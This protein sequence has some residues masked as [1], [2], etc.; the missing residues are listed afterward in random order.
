MNHN[1]FERLKAYIV[2]VL[3]ISS[4][5]QVGILWGYQSQ[6]HGF[7]IS[8]LSGIFAGG[9]V[10]NSVE[11][12]EFFRP[13]TI[14]ASSNASYRVIDRKNSAYIKLWDDLRKNYLPLL[15]NTKPVE[16]SVIPFSDDEWG[17]IIAK[18]GFVFDFKTSISTDILSEFLNKSGNSN[19]ELTGIY[20]IAVLP[21]EDINNNLVMYIRDDS[22][23]SQYIFP[24]KG[25]LNRDGYEAILDKTMQDNNLREY[26][27]IRGLDPGKKVDLDNKRLYPIASDILLALTLPKYDPMHEV[28]SSVPDSF[29][30]DKSN[31]AAGTKNLAGVILGD[32]KDIYE[33]AFISDTGDKEASLNIKNEAVVYKSLNNMYKVYNNGLLEY[34]SLSPVES[35]KIDDKKAF[36]N[37]LSFINKEKQLMAAS[38]VTLY[39]SGIKKVDMQYT[40]FTF[41]YCIGNIPVFAEYNPDTK[42]ELDNAL[43]IRANS[44]RVLNAWWIVRKF[45][46]VSKVKQYDMLFQD[47]ID[48]SFKEYVTLKKSDDFFINSIDV[49]YKL[50]AGNGQQNMAPSWVVATKG[51]RNYVLPV[52]AKEGD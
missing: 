36:E 41:D 48:K 13:F 44:K 3:L 8:F 11:S 35:E 23:I 20:K 31:L 15:L 49:S 52:K 27:V 34:K 46:Q 21:W 4:C 40:Q 9:G 12:E 22:K 10:S 18:S 19:K 47:L 24:I 51:G 30:I 5:I 50:Y 33:S 14:V 43:T 6:N 17:D 45:E 39:L 38:G 26:S 1:R 28:T 7:P 42:D 29:A 2:L 16:D 25:Q 37:A 32:E